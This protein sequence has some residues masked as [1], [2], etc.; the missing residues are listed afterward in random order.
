LS[1]EDGSEQADDRG[2]VGEDAEDISA[3][4]DLPVESLLR[5]ADPDL[6]AAQL[7]YRL[8]DDPALTEPRR[9]FS[10]KSDAPSRTR[11]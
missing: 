10:W 9:T 5:V 7:G 6:A 8:Q 3:P 4:A 2:T 1:C 11:S